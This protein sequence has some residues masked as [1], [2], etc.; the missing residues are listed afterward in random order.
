MISQ[1]KY[2]MATL[3]TEVQGYEWCAGKIAEDPLNCAIIAREVGA[4][5]QLILM[6]LS[7]NEVVVEQACKVIGE[8]SLKLLNKSLSLL[9]DAAALVPLEYCHHIISLM[10][11]AMILNM[12]RGILHDFRLVRKHSQ[13]AIQYCY[14]GLLGRHNSITTNEIIDRNVLA[15]MVSLIQSVKHKN[16]LAGLKVISGLALSS[17]TAAKKL[18]TK[19]LLGGLK[20][21]RL[22][23]LS[24]ELTV[25]SCIIWQ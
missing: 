2:L 6:A 24:E 15:T 22:S 19:E 16:Q 10:Q 8:S 20:V 21:D 13:V 4:I 1:A 9:G 11:H 3:S 5:Q 12:V 18:L 14:A 7:E 17:E 25:T 23:Y